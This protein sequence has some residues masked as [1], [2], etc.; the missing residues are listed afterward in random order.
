MRPTL[1]HARDAIDGWIPLASTLEERDRIAHRRQRIAE[2]VREHGEKLVL[3]A[4]G[5]AQRFEEL[6]F[7]ELP[8]VRLP[9]DLLRRPP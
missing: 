3:A 1:D 9:A 8:G 4:I 7:G 6:I 5:I 2:F